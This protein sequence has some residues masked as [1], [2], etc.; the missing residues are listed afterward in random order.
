MQKFYSI[1]NIEL[2][3]Q[4][5]NANREASRSFWFS[6]SFTLERNKLI[7]CWKPNLFML[8]GKIELIWQS[9]IIRTVLWRTTSYLRRSYQNMVNA[10]RFRNSI[11]CKPQ[12]QAFLSSDV[13]RASFKDCLIVS[14]NYFYEI[15]LDNCELGLYNNLQLFIIRSCDA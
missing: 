1:C 6:S 9:S 13:S 10:V 8:F 11:V 2:H 5:K 15:R 7:Q 3:L 12:K 14:I 4:K